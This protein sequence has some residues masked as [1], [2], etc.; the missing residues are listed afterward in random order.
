MSTANMTYADYLKKGNK[1]NPS[2]LAPKTAKVPGYKPFIDN[3]KLPISADP[4]KDR[5]RSKLGKYAY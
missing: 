1:V 4:R 2:L 3:S 5:S